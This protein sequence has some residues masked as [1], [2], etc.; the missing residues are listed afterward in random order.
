[1]FSRHGLVFTLFRY[2]LLPVV[3]FCLTIV[4]AS[5]DTFLTNSV[6]KSTWPRTVATVVRS[7]DIGRVLA[8]FQRTKQTFSDP[9]GTLEYV[10]DG[11]THTWQGRGQD[12]GVTVMNPGDKIEIYYN[13]RDPGE[14]S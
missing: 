9:R 10:I 4:A 8:E 3:V 2:G 6:R 11:Q 13:P 5:V 7:E 14:I 12:V 1:M